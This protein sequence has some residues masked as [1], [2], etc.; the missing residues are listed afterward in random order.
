M[1]CDG[2]TYDASDAASEG[3]EPEQALGTAVCAMC[4][5]SEDGTDD[6]EQGRSD[7]SKLAPDTVTDETDNDLTDD[8]AWSES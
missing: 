3:Q 7:Q 6:D 5:G 1:L 2:D 4:G 8:S